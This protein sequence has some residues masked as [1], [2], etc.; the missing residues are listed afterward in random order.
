MNTNIHSTAVVDKS[1]Q[2]AETAVIGPYAI[3]GKG[4]VIESGGYVGPHSVVEYT[5]LSEDASVGPFCCIGSPP[6]DLAYDDEPTKVFIGRDVVIRE[7]CTVHRG[8]KHGG[9][10]T[11]IGDRCY[12]M[13]YSHVGHDC[14]LAED[15]ILGNHVALGGHVKV[16]RKAILNAY[17]AAH[18]HV[19]VGE[20]AF[21]IAQVST[22]SSI[23]PYVMVENRWAKILR[24]NKVGMQRDNI[25]DEQIRKVQWA[26]DLLK[27]RSKEEALDAIEQAL[28]SQYPQL[29]TIFDFYTGA[30]GPIVSFISLQD[31]EDRVKAE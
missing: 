25:S 20:L 16:A 14:F 28:D 19:Q 15:V 31:R 5:T 7:G 6:Q 2:I 18:Q 12:L 4:V 8:T 1:A 30:Q 29:Q 24:I 3:I 27:R 13:V 9:G 11:S 22:Q 21:G 26:Y 23:P 10:L 17:F